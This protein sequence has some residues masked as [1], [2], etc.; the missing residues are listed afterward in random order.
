MKKFLYKVFDF[1]G[2]AVGVL[3]PKKIVSLPKFTEEI[4]GGQG[5]MTISYV[6][7]F[8]NFDT[9]LVAKMNVIKIYAID[10]TNPLGRLIYTG[11]TETITPFV[12]GAKIGINIG[13]LG[14]V[15]L[16]A[17]SYYKD[18]SNFTV[19]HT[20]DDPEVILKAIIDHFNTIY[21]AGLIGY[22]GGNIS[23]VG[24]AIDYEFIDRKWL[25]A[26]EDTHSYSETDWWWRINNDGEVYLQAKPATPTHIFT[27]GKDVEKLEIP[28]DVTKVI[29]DLQYR[30]GAVDRDYDDATS[31]TTYGKRSEIISDTSTTDAT[32]VDQF[33]DKYIAEKKDPRKR[34]TAI[35]NDAYDL[36]SIRVGETCRF[37]NFKLDATIVDDNMHI[38]SVRYTPDKVTIELEE[39]VN[40]DTELKNFIRNATS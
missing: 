16:L 25:D 38:T 12:S 9:D 24:Q 26:L 37:E 28:D 11:V 6:D 31:Q 7:N 23:T 40:L 35:I 27:I 10:T 4:N 29:N 39:K 2:N 33:G 8:D 17:N 34:A 14:L 36:E 22:A 21:P 1:N 15:S 20:S 19:T 32:T 3:N 13:L 18:G 30:D 5:A